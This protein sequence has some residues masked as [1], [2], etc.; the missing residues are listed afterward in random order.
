[1]I[2]TIF[3]AKLQVQTYLDAIWRLYFIKL[4]LKYRVESC[5][6]VLVDLLQE[7]SLK[8]VKVSV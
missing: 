2:S 6:V 8:M 1:M 5:I 3:S 4:D 7:V